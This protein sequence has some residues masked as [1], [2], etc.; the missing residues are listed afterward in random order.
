VLSRQPFELLITRSSAHKGTLSDA[1][2][3]V[4]GEAGDV[5][6]SDAGRPSAEAALHLEIA[7]ARG[8]SAVLHTHSI[9][10]TML[11]EQYGHA[12]GVAIHGYEMLKGLSGV[13]THEHREWVPVVANDQNM[14]R[15]ARVVRRLVDDHPD[16][17][18][19]LIRGHGLYTWGTTLAEAERHVEILEF[20][21]EV[22]GRTQGSPRS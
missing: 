17:H 18:G 8:A 22:M 21:F 10:S 7:Q 3:L 1:D 2:L 9:W 12:N 15:L 14:P 4:V 16:M 13:T 5:I 11:S 19:F 20:L 6:G